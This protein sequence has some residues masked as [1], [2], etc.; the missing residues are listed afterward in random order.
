MTQ[1]HRQAFARPLVSSN[2]SHPRIALSHQTAVISTYNTL[3][4]KTNNQ[5]KGTIT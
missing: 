1:P 4:I 2:K 5:H 3:N